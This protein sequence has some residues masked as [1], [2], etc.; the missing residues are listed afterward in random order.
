MPR[1]RVR[2]RLEDGLRLH[3]SKL[4]RMGF[5]TG[6]PAR[7]L[8]WQSGSGRIRAFGTILT[9]LESPETGGCMRVT[10][11]ETTQE[12]RLCAAPRHYGGWQWYFVCPYTGQ[13]STVLWKPPGAKKFGSR[14]AWG[15]QV[16]Y[17]SQFINAYHRANA[18]AHK[19]H[20]RLGAKGMIDIY[21]P[22]PPK[23]RGMYWR[24]YEKLRDRRERYEEIAE[25][26]VLDAIMG[27]SK[28]FM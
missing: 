5:L 11:D 24:T 3:L 12:I 7:S 18:S 13:R 1:Q 20:Y 19:I 2:V 26:H 25:E 4:K 16:A 14:Q 15:R 17:A 9:T 27:F 22:L 8:C 6:Y 10:I 23:P 28:R 21:D